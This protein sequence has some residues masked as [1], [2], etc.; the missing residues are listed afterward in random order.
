MSLTEEEKDIIKCYID[1]GVNRTVASLFDRLLA[2]N[3]ELRV[4]KNDTS[5]ELILEGTKIYHLQA[6]LDAIKKAT[7][8]FINYYK[9]AVLWDEG[10]PF[11]TTVE[12]DICSPD[13]ND[14]TQYAILKG[15]FMRLKEALDRL[16]G[17]KE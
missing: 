17:G 12:I 6:K 15:D 16:I 14:N 3:E 13:P 1:F 9:L 8:P 2:E 11:D 5:N 10:E 7:E 4:E